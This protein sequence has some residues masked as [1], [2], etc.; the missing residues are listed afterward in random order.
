[1]LLPFLLVALQIQMTD[2]D[3]HSL[4]ERYRKFKLP[5]INS[6]KCKSNQNALYMQKFVK[7]Q[8]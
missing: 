3:A 2:E 1:M 6:K 8:T 4:G 5:I 7:E